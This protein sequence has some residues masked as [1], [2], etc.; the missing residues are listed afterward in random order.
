MKEFEAILKYLVEKFPAKFIELLNRNGVLVDSFISPEALFDRIV[1]CMQKSVHFKTEAKLLIVALMEKDTIF[2]NFT[3]D[4]FTDTFSNNGNYAHADG[5][6]STLP[7]FDPDTD[8]YGNKNP[9]PSDT[10]KKPSDTTKKPLSESTLGSIFGYIFKT[11]DVFLENK[12]TDLEI[13]KVETASEINK[14]KND[15]VP[16]PP[17][18]TG[19]YV[20]LGVGGLVI[21]GVIVFLIR[22]NQK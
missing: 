16:P 12:Q 15:D 14:N 21:T 4:F 1:Y 17:N 19:L 9:K 8:I 18:K 22:K 20:G 13:K 3:D 10:T 6:F 7:K 5:P 11:A 2:A